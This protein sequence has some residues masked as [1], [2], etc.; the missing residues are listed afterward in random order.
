MRAPLGLEEDK[1]AVDLGPRTDRVVSSGSASRPVL[2]RA[3]RSARA[4]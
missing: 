3:W 2:E 1:L 4:I